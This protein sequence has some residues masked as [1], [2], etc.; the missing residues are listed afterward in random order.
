MR[1]SE[2][3]DILYLEVNGVIVEDKFRVWG[4]VDVVRAVENLTKVYHLTKKDKYSFF[5]KRFSKMNEVNFE[6]A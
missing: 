2:I 6:I 1:S 4:D 5:F 3:Y